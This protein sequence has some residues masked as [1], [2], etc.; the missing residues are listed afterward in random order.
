MPSATGGDE[1]LSSVNSVIGPPS[2]PPP[3]CTF[4]GAVVLSFLWKLRLSIQTV[5]AVASV[6]RM[7][8]S[9]LVAVV[10]SVVMVQVIFVQPDV[11]NV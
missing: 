7:I 2:I 3:I 5:R 6:C 11:I 4:E 9:G 8:R 10:L 1:D